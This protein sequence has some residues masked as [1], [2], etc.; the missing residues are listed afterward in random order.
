MKKKKMLLAPIISEAL[1]RR[2]LALPATEE[3]VAIAEELARTDP[4]PLPPR[5]FATIDFNDSSKHRF[6]RRANVDQPTEAG[7]ARAARDGNTIP[8]EIEKRMASDRASADEE[9]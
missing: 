5:L 7:L 8:D 2:G 6:V 4:T 3:D 1:K 9:E